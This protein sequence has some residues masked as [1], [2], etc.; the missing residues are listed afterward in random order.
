MED[1]KTLLRVYKN[2]ETM[3][4]SLHVND[5]EEM[6]AV[7]LSLDDLIA[8]TPELR[9]ALIAI[10]MARNIDKDFDNT[11]SEGTVWVPDFD[12]LLKDL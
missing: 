5:G 12:Q 9:S 7:A 1:E 11:I 2:D 3:A 10:R 8:Q 4:V 6:L